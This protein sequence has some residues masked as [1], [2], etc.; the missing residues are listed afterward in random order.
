MQHHA[1]AAEVDSLPLRHQRE[2]RSPAVVG[3]VNRVVRRLAKGGFRTGQRSRR[4][5]C[6]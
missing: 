5:R 6:G 4:V 2:V 1:A 3:E